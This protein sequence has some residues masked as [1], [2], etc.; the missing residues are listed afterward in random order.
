MKR[1]FK[2]IL[3]ILLVLVIL[4][5]IVWYLFGYDR[6]IMQD[7][8]LGSARYF[9]Q[10]G[11]H[12]TATWL[13]NQAYL[14]SGND[15]S[16]IIELSERFKKIGNYTQAEVVLTNAI[17]EG[18]T[19][20][21]YIALSQTYV[22]QDKLMDAVQ[23]LENITNPQIKE[24]LDAMRPSIPTATPES[25]Y[26]SQYL[27]VTIDSD[28]SQKLLTSTTAEFPSVHSSYEG[29]ITLE[30]G[31]NNIYAVAVNDDGLVSPLAHFSY[32]VGGVIEEV[33][34]SDPVLDNHLR[35]LL[36]VSADTKLYSNDLWKITTLTV[37]KGVEAFTD[38]SRLVYLQTLVIE[39]L[40]LNGLQM[41]SSLGQL[42]ELTIRGT[43]LSATDLSVIGS[44]P[45]LEKLTLNNCSL[46]NISGLSNASR[47][48]TLDLSSNAIKD[49]A[50]LSFMGN[51]VT[52]NMS[53]NALTNLSPLSALENLASLNVSYNS[54]TSIAPLAVCPKLTTL[55]AS[56]NKLAEMPVFDDPKILTNLVLANNDLTSV[57]SLASYTSLS[58][59]DLAYNNLTNASALAGLKQLAS[60]NISHNKLTTLP[61]WSKSCALVELDASYNKITSVSAL[62]GLTKLNNVYLDYNKISNIN[63]LADCHMLVRVSI[64]GNYVK[65]VSKL[66]AMSVIVNWNPT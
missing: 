46:T 56:N 29:G 64:Y 38:L 66:T 44:L 20:E 63:P 28:N 24:Q 48:T 6:G 53:S 52:L 41:L 59:L 40:N 11:N 12:N 32:I 27:T 49:L 18:A 65:D 31:E 55:I 3:P 23:M 47:L 15:A 39:N 61:A 30:A 62:R 17:K 22:E 54:L 51:L 5:S 9:E 16:V 42:K 36:N 8:L 26:Y 1:T 43:P 2:R 60:V 21:L 13:Y 4:C 33:T 25:G 37:P 45:S 19:A 57:E 7:I 35:T 58:G 50:P 10:Q 34:I 14:H